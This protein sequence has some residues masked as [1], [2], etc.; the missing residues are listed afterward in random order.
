MNYEQ[1][2]HI[3]IFQDLDHFELTKLVDHSSLVHYN[4]HHSFFIH[5]DS[6]QYFY[7]IISGWVK[8]FR[9]TSDGQEALLG[10]AKNGDIIGEVNFDKNKHLFSAQTINETELLTI[11]QS[12][13]KDLVETNAKLAL[14]VITSL[15]ATINHLELQFEHIN[16]MNAAQRVGCFILKLCDIKKNE[17]IEII[18]P[19]DKT[20]IAAYLGMKRE[21]FSRA[22]N[23]L[24][25]IGI[26][27][28]GNTLN[29]ENL[30]KLINF[31][32]IS[33]SLI[34]DTCKEVF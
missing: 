8:L 1:I 33:C 2:K 10:L 16:T 12:T 28:K 6:V 31:S 23:E 26:A 25:S 4:K 15:N 3:P 11:P 7:I 27:V 14:R 17:N 18:L 19:Y 5:G 24:K 13:L 20:L 30:D 21:T 22:L 29:I 34:Y 9:D 32:C